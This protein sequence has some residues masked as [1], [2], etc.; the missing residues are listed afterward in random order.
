MSV[1]FGAWLG[2]VAVLGASVVAH[3]QDAGGEEAPAAEIGSEGDGHAASSATPPPT[4]ELVAP[5]TAP[6]EPA[7]PTRTTEGGTSPERVAEAETSPAAVAVRSEPPRSEP[8]PTA[9]PEPDAD[10]PPRELAWYERI[11]IRGYTQLRY[12][13]LPSLNSND[14]LINTQG[15]R[16]IGEGNGFA[17]RR[18]RL[19]IFGDLHEHLSI[20]L[21]PDFASTAGTQMHALVLRDWYADVFFDK[22]HRFRLRLG[23]SKVPYGFENLQSS[24]NRL[25]L[26]RNDALNSAVRDERDI[27]AFFYWTPVEIQQ[28]FR[29]L[30]QSG[31]KGSGD[32]GVIGLGIYNG[33]TANQPALTDD[34]HVI[35]RFAY[36]FQ[37]GSQFVEI[38]FGGYVGKYRVTL[39]DEEGMSFR[40]PDGNL[41]LLD[42]R[43]FGTIVVYPQPF[44][45]QAEATWG[46]GPQ[47]GRRGNDD[48]AVVDSR[49]LFGAYAQI[50]LKLDG[51]LGTVSLIPYVR[52]TYYDGGKKF[53]VNAPHYTVRELEI[54]IEW[55]LIRHLEVVLA[56]DLVDRTSDRFPYDQQRGHVTRVQVQVNLP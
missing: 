25:A 21:Q 32:Y 33:Q 18:A 43:V 41:S 38:G 40:T 9:R 28:R 54:G 12:N 49:P 46:V 27:G 42:A 44:G 29:H 56:Y 4:L 8:S 16:S 31:L 20:Y 51:I 35:G 19:I 15:D 34:L 26:D 1:G 14:D 48:R 3:A 7:A 13:R 11:S 50:M 30:V 5:S 53:M 22:A 45:F 17:I 37:F 55:Q 24:Q 39:R 36:P 10:A 2:C 52:G 23:Q 47:Q 6:V